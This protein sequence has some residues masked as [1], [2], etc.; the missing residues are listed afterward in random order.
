MLDAALAQGDRLA[1][2]APHHGFLFATGI[3]NSAPTIQ[4]GRIRRDQMEEC[5]HYARWREDLGAGQGSRLRRAALWP[6]APPHAARPRPA[7]L[8]LRR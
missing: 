7:R 8:V 6:A 2:L 4:G 5:G 3:E 1:S